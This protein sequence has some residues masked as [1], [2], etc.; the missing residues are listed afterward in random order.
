MEYK[1][2]IDIIRETVE[3]EIVSAITQEVEWWKLRCAS[4]INHLPEGTTCNE[5]TDI[6]GSL[7]QEIDGILDKAKIAESEAAMYKQVLCKLLEVLLV[8][9]VSLSYLRK[10]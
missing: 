3:P 4:L 10:K 7:A 5:I 8:S 2:A 9:G 1:N 6:A